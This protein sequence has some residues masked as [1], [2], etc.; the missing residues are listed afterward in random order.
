MSS[1]GDQIGAICAAAV[2]MIAPIVALTW[3]IQRFLVRG[4][5][6]GAVK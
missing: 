5:T 1:Q 6:F 3:V 4:L 2:T